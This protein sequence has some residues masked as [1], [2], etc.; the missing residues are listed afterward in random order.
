[1]YS[2]YAK[3]IQNKIQGNLASHKEL[4]G[5]SVDLENDIDVDYRDYCIVKYKYDE[6]PPGYVDKKMIDNASATMPKIYFDMEYNCFRGDTK[7]IT[8]RGLRNIENIK[9][10]D[11]VLTHRGRF[12]KVTEVLQNDYSGPMI[13]YKT[14]GCNQNYH[15]T[16]NHPY[17]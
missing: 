17:S 4:L 14:W 10:G 15:V 7:I 16:P 9:I 1:M 5:D 12:R 6:L 3:I 8:D 13:K 11:K 2:Q